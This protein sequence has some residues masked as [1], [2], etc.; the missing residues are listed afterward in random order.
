[1]G[2]VRK[3]SVWLGIL[4]LVY[5]A[6]FVLAYRVEDRH[7]MTGKRAD[8]NGVVREYIMWPQYRNWLYSINPA[9]PTI[10]VIFLPCT[11]MWELGMSLFYDME[12]D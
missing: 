5:M 3:F 12:A 7:G 10:D 2:F 9:I 6:I 8:A 4:L 11:K 1:M